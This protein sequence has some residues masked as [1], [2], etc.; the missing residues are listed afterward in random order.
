MLRAEP[1]RHQ[2]HLAQQR[3]AVVGRK[4]R[5][6]PRGP[7]PGCPPAPAARRRTAP[8]GRRPRSGARDTASSPGPRAA[9]G[10]AR[11]PLRARAARARRCLRAGARPSDTGARLPCR[12]ARPSRRTC[13]CRACRDRRRGNSGESWHRS[14]RARWRCGSRP[15]SCDNPVVNQRE[16]RIG[17]RHGAM[18]A[19]DLNAAAMRRRAI[20][21]RGFMLRS[22]SSCHR[23][24]R[25]V[26]RACALGSSACRPP[27]AR[28]SRRCP[29]CPTCAPRTTHADRPRRR[30]PPPQARSRRARRHRDFQ[31]RAPRSASDGDASLKGNVRRARRAT[32]RSAPKTCSTSQDDSAFKVEGDVE[33]NDPLVHV[34]GGGG[35]YSATEG[36]DFSR[37]RVRA[38]RARRARRGA[39]ACSSRPKAS[40]S[41]T[42]CASP[43]A[44]ERHVVAA[45][46]GR[47]SRSTRARASARAAARAWT[48]RA[49]RSCTCRGCR[50]RSAPSARAASCSRRSGTR[51]RS[52]V[53]LAVPYYWNIAPNAD[54]TFEPTYTRGA[55]STSQASSATSRD[56]ARQARR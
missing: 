25:C 7:S 51:T 45:A 46:R 11:R 13:G 31:R 35:S 49:C 50:S 19:D 33:Y 39:T 55:A 48:S 37:R 42:A 5:P 38:A 32:A 2:R 53:Q 29:S 21:M 26:A 30:A 12:A 36:A 23:S 16:A 24:V 56:A 9:A 3:L 43:P 47:A 18:R 20:I 44:R 41:S 6:R 8:R 52:G 54:L 22:G 27:C 34:T 28:R 4:L 1:L 40:S 14:R 17:W 15:R 10:R